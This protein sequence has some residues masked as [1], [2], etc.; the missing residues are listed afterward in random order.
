ML[1]GCTTVAD[2]NPART[3]TE[4]LVISS[5]AE[6]AAAKLSLDIPRSANVFLDNSNFEGTDSKYAIAAIRSHL[7]ETGMQLVDD[8]KNADVIIEMRAGAL[9]TDRKTF[10]I[11]IPQFNI[12][13]PL[14]SAP[15]AIPQMA[16]YSTEEQKGVAKFAATGFAAKAGTLIAAQKPQYGFSHNTKKTVLF[17]FSWTDNDAMPKDAE[18]EEKADLKKTDVQNN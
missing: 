7:L 12:P 9:S 5:A 16:I 15:L 10:L 13:I 17:F 6:R 14:A 18:A 1:Q 2:S 11:G 8:K 3:A 4:Q